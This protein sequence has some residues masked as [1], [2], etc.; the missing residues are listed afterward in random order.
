MALAAVASPMQRASGAAAAATAV[1]AKPQFHSFIIQNKSTSPAEKTFF[2]VDAHYVLQKDKALGK[3]A[4]GVVAAC[5]DTRTNTNVAI[6]RVRVW[7]PHGPDSFDQFARTIREIEYLC[8][9]KHPNIVEL[10]DVIEPLDGGNPDVVYLVTK[11]MDMTLRAVLTEKPCQLKPEHCKWFMYGLL[12]GLAFIHETGVAHRDIKPEN[13]FLNAQTPTIRIGDFGLARCLDD[14][15]DGSKIS[16]SGYVATRWYRAPEVICGGRYTT[17]MDVWSAGCV[18]YEMMNEG[19]PL[20][21]GADTA[22]QLQEIF[23]VLGS[24]ADVVLQT[25]CSPDAYERYVKC[26]KVKGVDWTPKTLV[27]KQGPDAIDLLRGLLAYDPDQRLSAKAALRHKYFDS[28]RDPK[29][30]ALKPALRFEPDTPANWPE[31]YHENELMLWRQSMWRTIVNV[32]GSAKDAFH[33]WCSVYQPS[34]PTAA[35]PAAFAAN[36]NNNSAAACVQRPSS[37]SNAATKPTAATAAADSALVP[38]TDDK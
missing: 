23:R 29:A 26:P 4:E 25:F 9:L 24:P 32:R 13:L 20:F 16:H 7:S 37:S 28:M 17:Q 12:L 35:A 33:K 15:K 11:R 18:M 27:A 6:K 2:C 36:N 38:M 30:E 8:K 5:V 31:E 21:P 1:V 22:H 14:E 3:G 34:K 10:L 19:E